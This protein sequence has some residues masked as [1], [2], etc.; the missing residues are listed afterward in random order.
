MPPSPKRTL[1]TY[2]IL[3]FGLSSI[4]YT[5]IIRAGTLSA[6][7]GLYVLGLMWCPGTAGILTMLITT[8]SLRGMGWG[9]G[10]P[11]WLAL[12][13]VLPVLYG[14][15][16]YGVV[17]TAG[18]GTFTTASLGTNASMGRFVALAATL[19]V[20][21]SLISATG[22]EIG[23]RGV[24]VPQLSRVTGFTGTALISSGIW[25]LWHTPVLLFA[26]Y[27]SGTPWWYGL[28]CFAIMV[29]GIGTAFAWLRLKSGSLWTGALLHA[30]HNLFIQGVFDRTTADSGHTAWITGEF[31]IALALLA[32]VVGYVFWRQR[33]SLRAPGAA[34]APA[35]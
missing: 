28:S 6:A 12:A 26:D 21:T 5:L 33:G 31:G 4:F 27:N 34:A 9:L 10:N 19:G 13:Y 2:L 15:V 25:A 8:R 22:E 29:L 16:A 11:K 17:W 30:S 7:H 23:W 14:S 20:A 1:T 24:L 3:T 18:W 35:A 32:V